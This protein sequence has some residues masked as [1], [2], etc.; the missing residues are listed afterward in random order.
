M[1]ND[2]FRKARTGRWDA[3][4]GELDHAKPFRTTYR[5]L[6]ALDPFI[7]GSSHLNSSQVTPIYSNALMNRPWTKIG[8]RDLISCSHRS[9]HT[10]SRMSRDYAVRSRLSDLMVTRA[11]KARPPCRRSIHCSRISRWW[12][13]SASLVEE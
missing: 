3:E 5:V 6:A 11:N 12:M 7:Y 2:G 4:S 13:L 1:A 8:I 9:F 10:S